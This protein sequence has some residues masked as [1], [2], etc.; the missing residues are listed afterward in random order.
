MTISKE[1]REIGKTV[2]GWSEECRMKEKERVGNRDSMGLS[3]INHLHHA[4]T[5][6]RLWRHVRCHGAPRMCSWTGGAGGV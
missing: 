2:N 4:V 3:Y 5:R 6:F 1:K